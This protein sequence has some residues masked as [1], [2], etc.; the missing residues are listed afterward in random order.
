MVIP[1]L[2]RFK[3]E[4]GIAY[5]LT[6]FA[7]KTPAVGSATGESS[8]WVKKK[9]DK[10]RPKEQLRVAAQVQT[11]MRLRLIEGTIEDVAKMLRLGKS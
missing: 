3:S 1:L 8:S 5:Y 4:L 11:L 6:P 2:G 10:E 7:A 9:S